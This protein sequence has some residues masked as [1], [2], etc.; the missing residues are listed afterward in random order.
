MITEIGKGPIIRFRVTQF[1]L[2]NFWPF[3]ALG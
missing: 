1:G 3:E 2:L